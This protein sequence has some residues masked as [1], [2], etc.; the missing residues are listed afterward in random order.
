MSLE[1]NIRN[2]ENT[3]NNSKGGWNADKKLWFPH[4]SLEGGTKTIAYG[5]KLSWADQKKFEEEGMSDEDANKLFD[6]DLASAKEDTARLIKAKGVGKLDDDA[7]DVLTEMT[8]NLG[9][10]GLSQFN[11]MWAA[12][13]KES[14][15]YQKAAEEMKDSRWYRESVGASRGNRMVNTMKGAAK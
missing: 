3:K 6:I 8:Y 15:D 1:H 7:M 5:H 2:A 13:A 14:P 12:L 4:N 9:Q 10:P 11:K